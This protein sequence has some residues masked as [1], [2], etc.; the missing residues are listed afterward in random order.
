MKRLLVV[1]IAVLAACSGEISD[2]KQSAAEASPKPQPPPPQ[3]SY[4]EGTHAADA[5]QE[6]RA[7]VGEPFRVL[8]IDINDAT[9]RLRAQDP[10][11][12]ENVDEYTIRQGTIEPPAPVRLIGLVDQKT[13]E[14][15]LFDPADVDLTKIPDLLRQAGEKVQLEGGK[16]SGISITRNM[17]DESRP[18]IIDVDYR[19]TRKM[20]YLRADRHGAHTKVSIF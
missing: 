20:G 2:K 13:L 1:V 11:K 10:K 19:G 9:I 16:L 8:R 15:N 18:I 4:Y 14:A 7:K 5:I 6:I 17:F 12:K 3:V